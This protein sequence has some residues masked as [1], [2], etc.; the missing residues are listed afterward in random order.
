MYLIMLKMISLSKGQS[1][2]DFMIKE[3]KSK[4]TNRYKL[5]HYAEDIG[6]SYCS[7]WRFTNGKAV[8]EAV[9]PAF[10]G[11]ANVIAGAARAV[12]RFIRANQPQRTQ[13][14]ICATRSSLTI[15][16]VMHN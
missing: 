13:S 1:L 6:V 12:S 16:S 5:S 10:V 15:G 7:I 8:G 9:A 11:M 14:M 4:L 2:K 3:T